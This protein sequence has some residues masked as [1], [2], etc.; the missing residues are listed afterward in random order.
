MKCKV[1][2]PYIFVLLLLGIGTFYDYDITNAL[3][4]PQSIFGVIFEKG[5]LW[6]VVCLLPLSFAVLYAIKSSIWRFS[7]VVLSYS[8]LVREVTSGCSLPIFYI[9]ILGILLG[10]ITCYGMKKIN[11]E[12][13]RKYEKNVRFFLYVF[14]I[15]LLIT[16]IL[17]GCWGRVRY[18]ELQ[19]ITQFTNWYKIQGMNG[20][21]SFPSGH[22]TV[23]TSI[24]CLLPMTLKRFQQ[25]H[26][27]IYIIIFGLIIAMMASRLVMGAHYLS[28][29]AIGF[30]ITY[31]VYTYYKR[32]YYEEV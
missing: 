14:L 27:L 12:I 7:A 19:D 1:V 16:T 15:S 28:D 8:Y 4:N 22:T 24:L 32:K 9:L 31:S 10:V 29:T 23:F 6:L 21:F 11:V 17:K 30:C 20:N 25:K 3:Y 5:M 13:I 26:L 18:R 2:W